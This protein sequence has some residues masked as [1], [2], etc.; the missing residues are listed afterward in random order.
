MCITEHAVIIVHGNHAHM[1][2]L[3]LALV[4]L[5]VQ[6]ETLEFL[7]VCQAEQK[8]SYLLHQLIVP[9]MELLQPQATILSAMKGCTTSDAAANA[10]VL[11]YIGTSVQPA[12]KEVVVST[13]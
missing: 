6:H 13:S 10:A 3:V 2:V 8:V 7:K 9:V 5:V 12:A 11:A 1:K 4:L